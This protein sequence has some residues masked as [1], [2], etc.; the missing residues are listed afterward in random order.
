MHC[1]QPDTLL[2]KLRYILF[3]FFPC[4]RSDGSTGELVMINTR[5]TEP[6]D[7]YIYIAVHI[8]SL[9]TSFYSDPPYIICFLTYNRPSFAI[10]LTL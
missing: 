3:E 7:I 4:S 10:R 5:Q 8:A 6:I 9:F 2:P 1:A